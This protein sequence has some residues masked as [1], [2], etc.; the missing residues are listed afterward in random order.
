[1]KQRQP[2]H[3]LATAVLPSR[4]GIGTENDNESAGDI[5]HMPG[6]S[7]YDLSYRY[8]VGSRGGNVM[9]IGSLQRKPVPGMILAFTASSSADL[10]DIPAT[11]IDI[12]PRL[13]SGDYL[14]ELEYGEPVR[15]GPHVITRIGA[16]VS[17]LYGPCRAEQRWPRA[18]PSGFRHHMGRAVS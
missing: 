16:L 17:E 9:G 2:L 12:W 10:A 13:P 8:S 4:F 11:V 14:V 1:M 5:I 7:A 3:S 15:L 18:T 6:V